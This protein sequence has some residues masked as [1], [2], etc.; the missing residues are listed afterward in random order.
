MVE[1]KLVHE[2]KHIIS[3]DYCI[4]DL[5]EFEQIHL[6]TVN[7]SFVIRTAAENKK[8][9][10]FFRKYNPSKTKIE[11]EFEHSVITHLKKKRFALIAG[12]IHA[13]DGKT[14]VNRNKGQDHFYAIFNIL[15]GKDKY[16]WVNPDCLNH[17]LKSAGGV[18]A[19]FHNI[20]FDLKP[21][22]SRCEPKIMELL[23]LIANKISICA[24]KGGETPFDICLRENL[25]AII[26]TIDKTLNVFVCG[27]QGSEYKDLVQMV[28]HCD[29]HPGNL[30]FQNNTITGLFDFDWSKVDVR[31][32]DVALAIIYFCTIWEGNSDGSLDMAKTSIFFQN[33]Q[34]SCVTA[35]GPL[36]G[37]EL[38]YL[39]HMI[40]AANIY[41]INWI[42]QDFYEKGIIVDP[43]TYRKYL[44][45]HTRFLT[46]LEKKRNFS[47]L[48]KLFL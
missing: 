37:S 31:C 19:K 14:Y 34:N 9:T 41:V 30:K 45:H 27:V 35:P 22:Q 12:L 46:W 32:F 24:K 40:K 10:Y 1:E 38:K 4:G 2:L 36:N 47:G 7:K 5:I 15:P 17:D 26:A 48:E 8:S 21:E 16:S 28:I 3:T 42:I 43:Y 20:V 39:P 44:Q 13:K 18:L 6:G 25:D 23:P 11:I 33:Y 29:Y